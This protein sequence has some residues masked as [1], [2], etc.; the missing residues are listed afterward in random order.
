MAYFYSKKQSVIP[1]AA[2]NNS[3]FHISGTV[4][5]EGVLQYRGPLPNF[6]KMF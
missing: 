2:Y 1:L 4:N 6:T 5:E 3:L